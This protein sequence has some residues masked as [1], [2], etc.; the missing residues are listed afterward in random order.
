VIL[1]LVLR[2]QSPLHFCIFLRGLGLFAA[3]M[4][5]PQLAAAQ[6]GTFTWIGTTTDYGTVTNWTPGVVPTTSGQ[7]ASFGAGGSTSVIV[8]STIAPS[9]WNFT[10]SAQ[11]FNISGGAVNFSKAGPA[12]GIIDNASSGQTITISNNIGESTAGVQVQL[13]GQSTLVLSGTNTYSGGTTV[14]NFGVLQATNNSA[15]GSGTVTLSSGEFQAGGTSNLTFANTFTVLSTPGGSALDANGLTLTLSGNVGGAGALT[16]VDS[17][18]GGST[19]VLNGTNTYTGGTTICSCATLQL[20]DASHTASIVGTVKNDGQ[21]IVSNADTSGITF[22][23]N[24]GFT[25]FLNT[26]TAGTATI[27]NRSG[28]LLEFGQSGG[29]DTATAGTA[30]IDNRGSLIVFQAQTNAGSSSITNRS[31]S[32]LLF[33]DQASAA[34][35]TIVNTNSG[36]VFGQSLGS[37]TATAGSASITNNANGQTY[38]FALTNA[39][40]AIITANSG[41][42]VEF[43]DQSNGANAQFV[44]NGTGYVDFGEGTGPNGDGRITAGSIAGSGL[45]YIGGG[46]TLI[47]GS[48]NLSTTVSGV[49]ADNNPC[50]CTSGSGNLVKVGSGM[51]TLSGINT[52]S[53]TTTVNGGFLDVEGS[54]ASSSLTTVNAG[55]ALTGSGIVGNT[56]I[57]GGGIFLPGNGVGTSTSVNGNLA[58][59]AGALYLVQLSGTSSTLANVSGTATLAGN[60]SAALTPGSA[61][62]KQYTILAANSGV[63][64]SFAGATVAGSGGLVASLSYDANHAYLNLGLDYGAKYTLNG[65]QQ[66]VA[67]TLGNF[68]NANGG[69]P[70]ALASLTPNGLTQASGEVATGSQQATFQAMSLFI[71]LLTD[72]FIDGRGNGLAAGSAAQPYADSVM[73]YASAGSA[74]DA[75]ARLPTKADVARGDL[76]DQRWSVWGTAYGGGASIDGNGAVGSNATTAHAAGFA[77]GADYRFSP[78]T[79]AGF[80]LAGGGTSFAVNGFGSGRSDLFQAG[81][82]VR[83]TVG[84]AYISAA[85]AYGWQDVTTDRT[86]TAAGLDLLHAQFNANAYSG[87]VEGGYRYATPWM[88][89]TPYAAG[90]FTTFALP[91]YA[92]QVLAGTGNF[93]LNYAAKDV[94]DSRSELGFRTDRSIALAD[95]VMTLCS[96]F[97]WA[98]D[99]NSDRNVTAVFQTLPGA[100]FVVNGAAQA[101]DSALTTLSAEMK[102]LNG[103][104]AAATFEGEFSNVMQS[105]AGKGTVRYAW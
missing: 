55:G 28:G 46:H 75:L 105:Y 103:W 39:G 16:I 20:G 99:F 50:G 7:S 86:V 19:V 94:T 70:V 95:G 21:F 29:T 48:N 73:G 69:I 89:I 85:A 66:S 60:V 3:A 87:R 59:Q 63:S 97:A 65:N 68:F 32:E 53:G 43:H 25:Q 54:I 64:G 18:F 71:N 34:N 4:L 6:S 100:A 26:T 83:H 11:S 57:A 84:N 101:H 78:A 96:R 40:N 47:V 61:V 5:W 79:L 81:A 80:A 51:L 8:G 36:T 74:R 102:W 52:Y 82:F 67:N 12:G 76:F 14:S 98:H 56:I 23:T 33:L 49:I 15:V 2:F 58:F 9:A 30:T 22:I 44:T 88:G 41:G 92:E 38:F 62:V 45:Y 37:D 17:T 93:A 72:P 77:T 90:Q 91:A 42:F 1:G 13:L 31:G 104:S 10:S 24:T 35:A 27:N